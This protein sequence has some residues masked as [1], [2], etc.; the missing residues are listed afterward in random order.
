MSEIRESANRRILEAAQEEFLCHGYAR[1]SMRRIALK[2]RM[3]VGN[4]YQYY[5]S[6][7]AL[8]ARV[9]QAP[10]QQLSVLFRIGMETEEPMHQLVT[11]LCRVFIGCRIPFMVLIS[12]AE[13]SAYEGYKDEVVHIA[14]KRLA[15]TLHT[16]GANRLA[17]PLAV[18]LIEGLLSLFAQHEEDEQALTTDLQRYLQYMLHGVGPTPESEANS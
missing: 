6:K 18:S 16:P 17:D 14:R 13:G 10:V 11:G 2:A 9:V 8:F 5:R 12:H 7:E 3:T 15:E 4:I 1:A